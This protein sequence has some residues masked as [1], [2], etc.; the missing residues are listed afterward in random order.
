VGRHIDGFVDAFIGPPEWKASVDA[1]DPV[2]PARMRDEA[3][4]LVDALDAA[5]LE[6]DR[7]R[8]LRGQ[9][10]AI[11]CIT[12]RLG[13]VPMDWAE[14]VERC[15]GV[16]PTRTDTTEFE[17]ALKR[18]DAALEGSG[19]L[20]D[21]YKAWEEDNA[22]PRT[23]LVP[24]L[25]RLKE[26]LG[27]RAHDLA[28][29]PP[30]E[31]VGFE[32][33]SDKPW[34]AY[35]WF[36]GQHRSRIEINADLPISIVLLVALA[37]HE[38]YPGHHT[39]R[40]AKEA[41]LYRELDRIETSVAIIPAPESV[42]S[43]GIA[44]NA[45]QQALGSQPFDVVAEALAG[46]DISFDPGEAHELHM[47]E[48]GVFAVLTNAAFMLHE[49]GA[50]EDETQEYLSEWTLDSKEK[51]ERGVAFIG[52]PSARAYVPCYMEGRRLCSDFAN[53]A[54]GNF[55]RLLTE[56]LTTADLV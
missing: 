19:S 20:R 52:D 41:R 24:A 51:A 2:D 9:L 13:G 30:D 29:L 25:E 46:V 43:E 53:A 32:L 1:G 36:Q 38:A 7:R 49:D 14:E 45:L 55:T 26:V 48:D 44:T 5:D 47:A 8:W 17:S 54:P 4:L 6:D 28:P 22:V 21:R 27:P 3:L 15:L 16:R 18:L 10:V 31:S 35:N 12:A 42:I 50:S 37:A 23:K 56:Q 11:E 34:I 40:T 33:V 39:E